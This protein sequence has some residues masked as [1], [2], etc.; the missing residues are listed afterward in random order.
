MTASV[1][2]KDAV[3]AKPK[4]EE[5]KTD[6]PTDEIQLVDPRELL[7]RKP[8]PFKQHVVTRADGVKMRILLQGLSYLEK[9]KLDIRS[10][11]RREADEEAVE[12]GELEEIRPSLWAPEMICTAMCD[13]RGRRIYKDT[14]VHAAA[15]QFAEQLSDGEL[16][17]ALTA[18]LDV[19]G[20]GE[21]GAMKAGKSLK[22]TKTTG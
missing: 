6:Q 19:S 1:T 17:A 2:D 3:Q 11:T 9:Q 22:K 14:E 16:Q 18:V 13:P 4:A 8:M 20:W 21:D 7:I 5:A 10:R 12:R 15:L